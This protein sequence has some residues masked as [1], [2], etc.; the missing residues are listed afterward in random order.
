MNAKEFKGFVYK[1]DADGDGYI[2]PEE[3]RKGVKESKN[4]LGLKLTDEQIEAAISGID[5]DGDGMFSIKE[6]IDWMVSAG[7]LNKAEGLGFV[8]TLTGILG[9]TAYLLSGAALTGATVGATL[10]INDAVTRN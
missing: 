4:K 6:V 3:F 7:Y 2:S 10:A 8:L 5:K 1:L 9:A